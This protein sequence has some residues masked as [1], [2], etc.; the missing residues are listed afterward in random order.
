M[1]RGDLDRASPR[2][3]GAFLH[4]RS[5]RGAANVTQDLLAELSGLHRT[6]VSQLERGLRVPR[7]DTLARLSGALKLEP[8]ILMKGIAWVPPEIPRGQF[9]FPSRPGYNGPNGDCG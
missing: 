9:R 8:G 3:L 6:E 7:I 4:L 5:Q 2:S 1:R